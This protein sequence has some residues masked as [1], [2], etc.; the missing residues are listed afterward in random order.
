MKKTI[1]S[2]WEEERILNGIGGTG[3]TV[4]GIR[5]ESVPNLT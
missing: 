1:Y 4:N 2:G 5:R 3:T